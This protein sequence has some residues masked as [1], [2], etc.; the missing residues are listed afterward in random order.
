MGRRKDKIDFPRGKVWVEFCRKSL[1]AKSLYATEK[2]LESE[3]FVYD[4][5]S[6]RIACHQN[7]W[8][9]YRNQGVI[10]RRQ[11]IEQVEKVVPGSAAILNDPSWQIFRELASEERFDSVRMLRTLPPG[12]IKRLFIFGGEHDDLWNLRAVTERTITQLERRVDLAGMAAL[13]VLIVESSRSG[14]GELALELGGALFCSLLR[15]AAGPDR[16]MAEAAPGLFDVLCERVFPKAASATRRLCVE[17]VSFQQVAE[18]AVY[19]AKV[20]QSG[21]QTRNRATPRFD[22]SDGAFTQ[23]GFLAFAAPCETIKKTKKEP[24]ESKRCCDSSIIELW[25]IAYAKLMSEVKL[26]NN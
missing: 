17:R 4:E 10:P 5:K 7:K 11:L 15:M 3:A 1:N 20:R 13:S 12:I 24:K 18:L 25:G 8:R 26:V 16:V 19:L 23:I 6:G 22:F 21:E 14:K 2:A 9:R